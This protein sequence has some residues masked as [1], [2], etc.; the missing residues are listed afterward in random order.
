MGQ[1][2]YI[3]RGCGQSIRRG[4]LCVLRHVR[5][6][7]V[8][9]EVTG[10]YDGY[11]GVVNDKSPTRFNG[12]HGG[13][14]GHD[15]ITRS[16]FELTDS[17]SASTHSYRRVDGVLINYEDVLTSDAVTQLLRTVDDLLDDLDH[18][19]SNNPMLVKDAATAASNFSRLAS[20]Y[21]NAPVV[22]VEP[23][24]G[25]AAHHAACRVTDDLRPSESADDQGFGKP[26]ARFK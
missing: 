1:Y 22:Y 10:Y 13:V 12:D 25:V 18:E 26:R 8:L 14:N 20:D 4:E 3:C 15:E 16:E 24:S 21:R 17:Q 11:G 5:S 9:G 23:A 6:G 7:E 19:V 2:S